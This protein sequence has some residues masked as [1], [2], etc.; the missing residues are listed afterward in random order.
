MT[1]RTTAAPLSGYRQW[2]W[3]AVL[4]VLVALSCVAAFF[5]LGLAFERAGGDLGA[6]QLWLLLGVPAAVAQPLL[7]CWS[8][9][10]PVLVGYLVAVLSLLWPL[11]WFAPLVAWSTA[12]VH[13]P[14]PGAAEPA[15]GEEADQG[16]DLSIIGLLVAVGAWWIVWR[17]GRQPTD[18]GSLLKLVL[19]AT[20]SEGAAP[21]TS[22]PLPWWFALLFTVVLLT[23][24]GSAAMGLRSHH[25]RGLAQDRAL[26]AEGE[27]DRTRSELGRRAER[28]LVAQEVHDTLGHHLSLLSV[29]AGA[30]ELQTEGRD[31]EVTQRAA[32]V[33]EN[34]RRAMDD[35]RSLVGVL[36]AEPPAGGTPPLEE[37][38]RVVDEAVAGGDRLVATVYLHDAGEADPALSRAVHRIVQELLTNARKHAPGEVV[39]LELVGGPGRGVRVMARN[40]VVEPAREQPGLG[41]TGMRE[42]AELLGGALE[43]TRTE[44]EFVV[45]IG[46]PWPER[47]PG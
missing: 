25:E 32:V 37:I 43:V 20:Q 9:A 8:R 41:I 13:A 16:G 39:R 4:G 46:L 17:D 14:D 2:I 1:V 28:E 36:R 29:H 38:T 3:W 11:G 7:L 19:H 26:R 40:R 33:R 23:V 45:E 12:L 5:S 21:V 27:R 15:D 42:R 47:S 22:D 18:E 24:V 31:E 34:A 30:L 35:L 44:G 10:R 6:R